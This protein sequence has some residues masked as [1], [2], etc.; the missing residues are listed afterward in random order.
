[1]YLALKLA[2]RPLS[3]GEVAAVVDITLRQLDEKA[4]RDLL[5]AQLVERTKVKGE[6]PLY[7][8]RDDA[9]SIDV[10]GPPSGSCD[11]S[12]PRRRKAKLL[13]TTDVEKITGAL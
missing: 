12:H 11:G 6:E 4:G 1:M 8:I 2:K 10:S 13:D 3:L 9:P 5:H 7:R